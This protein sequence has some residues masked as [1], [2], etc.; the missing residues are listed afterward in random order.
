MASS[1][2]VSG[3]VGEVSTPPFRKRFRSRREDVLCNPGFTRIVL[4][5]ATAV[6]ALQEVIKVKVPSGVPLD[7][8]GNTGRRD[9]SSFDTW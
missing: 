2:N 7:L 4:P 8:V 6:N 9:Q 1:V 3:A 5:I